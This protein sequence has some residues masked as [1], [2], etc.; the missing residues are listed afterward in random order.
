ML[1]RYM[2]LIQRVLQSA[3]SYSVVAEVYIAT[4]MYICSQ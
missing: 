1:H 2:I 3:V 4:V